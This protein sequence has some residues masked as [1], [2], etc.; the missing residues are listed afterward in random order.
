RIARRVD[1]GG[2]ARQGCIREPQASSATSRYGEPGG[3]RVDHSGTE[4]IVATLEAV[5]AARS[6]RADAQEISPM[7]EAA[8]GERRDP[9]L[10]R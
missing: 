6:D 7:L 8:L 1:D 3:A 9:I 10:S 4:E 5:L 2:A